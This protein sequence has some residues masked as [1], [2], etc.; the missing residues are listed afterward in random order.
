MKISDTPSHWHD[1]GSPIP[2]PKAMQS[3]LLPWASTICKNYDFGS[4]LLQ[5][6]S[7][8]ELH[9]YRTI[10]N[11]KKNV[12]LYTCWDHNLVTLQY[13]WAGNFIYWLNRNTKLQLATTQYFLLYLAAGTYACQ[14]LPGTS[15]WLYI[16]TGPAYL[17]ELQLAHTALPK[18]LRNLYAAGNTG[19][20]LFPAKMSNRIQ[21]IIHEIYTSSKTGP[22]LLLEIKSQVYRLLNAYNEDITWTHYLENIRISQ[23]AKTI[24][25]VKNYIIGYPH[26]HACSLANLSK[27]FNISVAALKI[28]FKKQCDIPVSEFVQQQCFLKAQQLLQLRIGSIRDIAL[29]LGYSDVSNF[30]RAFRSYV[31]YAPHVMRRTGK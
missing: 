21:H 31:G 10:F 9:I 24:L 17:Q 3:R 5:E 4:I 12:K 18:M 29:Q 30:S 7:A 2:V 13:T 16:E 20:V 19:G 6:F 15:E 27:Q 22:S 8:T 25:A 11:I 26:I 14:L 1:N 28:N 23:T